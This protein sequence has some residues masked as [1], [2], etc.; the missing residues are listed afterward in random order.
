MINEYYETKK[1][2]RVCFNWKRDI[3]LLLLF[4][5]VL[6]GFD[7]PSI[8]LIGFWSGVFHGNWR[9]L[10]LWVFYFI[11]LSGLL[12]LLFVVNGCF[13]RG[14]YYRIFVRYWLVA[15]IVES[16][17]LWSLINF[18]PF[19]LV[20]NPVGYF[21]CMIV[22]IVFLWIIVLIPVKIQYIMRLFAAH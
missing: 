17:L 21:F 5:Y 9:R 7:L 10:A 18:S 2:E 1:N 4:S 13:I 19:V 6:S 20:L 22:L 14:V 11:A 8:E 3:A 12:S 15:S 16:N